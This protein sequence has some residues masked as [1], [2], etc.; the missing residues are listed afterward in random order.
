[1][2]SLTTDQED[3]L[4]KSPSKIT[5]VEDWSPDGRYLLYQTEIEDRDIYALD[6]KDGNKPIPVVHGP[7]WEGK[8]QISPDGRWI[9]YMS[10]ESGRDEIYVRPFLRSGEKVR[11]SVVRGDE[12]RWRRDGKEIVFVGEQSSLFAVP[13][14]TTP[15]FKAGTPQKLFSFKVGGGLGVGHDVTSDGKKLLVIVAEKASNSSFPVIVNWPA[16]LKK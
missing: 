7:A 15:T 10:M 11:V 6:L 14:T 5:R 2:R 16:D 12:P 3:L 1:M 13:V 8:G 9:T 4:Y